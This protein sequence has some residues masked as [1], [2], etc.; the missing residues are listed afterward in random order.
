VGEQRAIAAIWGP[1]QGFQGSTP[2]E[3][4]LPRGQFVQWCIAVR[5]ADASVAGADDET[6]PQGWLLLGGSRRDGASTTVRS[7]WVRVLRLSGVRLSEEPEEEGVLAALG[8]DRDAFFQGEVSVT[9]TATEA[10]ATHAMMRVTANICQI[11]E[12]RGGVVGSVNVTPFLADAVRSAARGVVNL[13]PYV[14][15]QP[16]VLCVAAVDNEWGGERDETDV[17]WFS[18]D[19]CLGRLRI[20]GAA[21]ATVAAAATPAGDFAAVLALSW[22]ISGLATVLTPDGMRRVHFGH[23]FRYD[24]MRDKWGEGLSMGAGG[25]TDGFQLLSVQTG[26]NSQRA[27]VR[28]QVLSFRGDSIRTIGVLD[29]SGRYVHRTEFEAAPEA[30]STDS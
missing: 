16:F 8:L 9:S 10:G 24:W 14:H 2:M 25:A 1:T 4:S 22:D 6:L 17:T 20:S 15:G 5:R 28:H 26:S 18:S 29:D 30:P 3:F 13:S 27:A 11:W 21:G 19:R 7:G 23:G 12:V